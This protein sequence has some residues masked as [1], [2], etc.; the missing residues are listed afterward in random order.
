MCKNND[1]AVPVC[2]TEALLEIVAINTQKK[3]AK[4]EGKDLTKTR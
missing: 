4:R 2:G 1:T 3:I